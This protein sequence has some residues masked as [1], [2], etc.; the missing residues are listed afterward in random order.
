MLVFGKIVISLISFVIVIVIVMMMMIMMMMIV[1]VMMMMMMMMMMIPYTAFD[2][3][4]LIF[5]IFV[6]GP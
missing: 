4:F 3:K 6:N 2:E 1:V 5:E